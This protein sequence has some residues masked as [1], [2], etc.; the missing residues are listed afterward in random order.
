MYKKHCY[1]TPGNVPYPFDAIVESAYQTGE[2]GHQLAVI[3]KSIMSIEVQ[4][5]YTEVEHVIVSY[6]INL[7]YSIFTCACTCHDMYCYTWLQKLQSKSKC[8]SFGLSF[9]TPGIQLVSNILFVY[10]SFL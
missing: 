10:K 8:I 9:F 7:S 4:I 3:D 1:A 2:K 6:N 5:V